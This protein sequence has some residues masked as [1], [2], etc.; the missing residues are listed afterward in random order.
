MIQV[1]GILKTPM[2]VVAKN[3]IVRVFAL[4]PTGDTLPTLPAEILTGSGGEYD[5][6][7]ENG[8]YTIEINFSKKYNLIDAVTVDLGTSTPITLQ[9]LLNSAT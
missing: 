5:F 4:E 7:L 8:E 3:V 9:N 2:G 1:T 6:T